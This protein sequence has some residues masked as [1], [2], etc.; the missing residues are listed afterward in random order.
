MKVL[1]NDGM[2]EEGIELFEIAGIGTDTQKKDQKTLVEVVGDYDALSVRSATSVTREII[3][4]G[5]KGNLKIVGRAGVGVDNIDDIAAS[6]HGILVK[7]APYGNTNAAAEQALFL[8][9]A[10]S[11]NIPQSHYSLK[12]G[13]W[14]KKPFKGVEVSHKTL[15]IIGCGRIGQRLSNLVSGLDM[16]VIGYDAFSDQVKSIFPESRIDYKSK[17]EVLE[18]SDYVSIHV[19]GSGVIIGK[20]ELSMMR[21]TAYLINTSRGSNVDEEAL[22]EALSTKSIA[23]AG[24]DVHADESK[25]EGNEFNSRLKGLDNVV[26]TS[27]LGASTDEAQKKTS[28]EMARVIIGYLLNGDYA[29]A[30]NAGETIQAEQKPVYPLFVHHKDAPGAFAEIGEVLREH[31]INIRENPSRQIGKD[32]TALTVYLLHN[33]FGSNVIKQLNALPQ[34]YSAKK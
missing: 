10:V 24:L 12:D 3:E 4:A 18:T 15:G 33:P 21:P 13:I 7:F 22:Y 23:G 26:L 25:K 6:E 9:G 32:G 2:D 29:N 1:L 14:L 5:A 31:N 8:M 34:V 16:G 17:E 30:V 20:Q 19:G 28:R 11:R 27:H